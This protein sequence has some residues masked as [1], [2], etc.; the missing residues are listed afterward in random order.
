MTGRRD[1]VALKRLRTHRDSTS[2]C[3]PPPLAP[4]VLASAGPVDTAQHGNCERL[5]R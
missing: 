2:V 4:P 1:T 3:R 5:R